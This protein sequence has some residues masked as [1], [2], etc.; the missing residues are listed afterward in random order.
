MAMSHMWYF[1]VDP[2]PSTDSSSPLPLEL[3]LQLCSLC[4]FPIALSGGIDDL[5][6]LL[7]DDFLADAVVH[8]DAVSTSS[9]TG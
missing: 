9:T 7:T 8:A 4:S 6:P 3:E 2:D 5:I 1:P